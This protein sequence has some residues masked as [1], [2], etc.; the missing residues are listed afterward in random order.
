VETLSPYDAA[1]LVWEMAYDELN[2]PTT[3]TF[4]AARYRRVGP[5]LKLRIGQ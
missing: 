4:G 3:V 1:D 5:K 2:R